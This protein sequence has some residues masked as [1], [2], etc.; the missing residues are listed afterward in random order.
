MKK[1]IRKIIDQAGISVF[2]HSRL[3]VGTDYRK[4]I[5]NKFDE[6]QIKV[7]FDVGANIGQFCVHCQEIFG[8]SDI[9]SFE[10]ISSTFDVLKD[11]TKGFGNISCFKLAFGNEKGTGEVFLQADSSVNSI[12]PLVNIRK[13]DEQESE[14]I[15]IDTI[16]L[17]CE[18]E[19]IKRIDLLK[20]DTEGFDL[21]VLEGARK[22]LRSRQIQF[23]FIEVTFD[24]DNIQNSSYNSI[25]SFLGEFGFK[26]H[27]LYNQ[28]IHE[29]STLMNYCDALFYLQPEE[30]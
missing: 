4:T 28:S 22:M 11:R 12:N 19:N 6:N 1:I 20:I 18:H 9:Y 2:R 14:Q 16:D 30:K 27:G 13:N 10:P 25:S 23:I 7:V 21:N 26:I 17:F 3:P 15:E 8:E 29:N 5:R 24:G